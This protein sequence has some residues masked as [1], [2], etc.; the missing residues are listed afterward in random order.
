VDFL[1]DPCS[2]SGIVYPKFLLLHKSGGSSH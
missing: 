1:H 2:P